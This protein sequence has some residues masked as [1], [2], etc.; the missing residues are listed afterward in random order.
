MKAE[1]RKARQSN[2]LA[3]ELGKVV[4]GIKHG[5]SRST[6]FYV[7]LAALVVAVVGLGVWLWRSSEEA[8]SKRWLEYDEILFPDQ[9][10]SFLKKPEVKGTPQ[11][12][13]ARFREARANLAQGIA[14]LGTKP[15]AAQEKL[16]KATELYEAL[17]TD[18]RRLPILHQEALAGAAR[19]NESLGNYDKAK[20]YYGLLAKEHDKTALGKE[21]KKQLDRLEGSNRQT[22]DEIRKELA[23]PKR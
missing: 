8:A 9:L 6:V 16:E 20:E 22:L 21:A 5:P 7:I 3:E 19:G 13:L 14:D 2:A 1:E 23:P 11:A 10:D 17:V 18:S 15:D 12:Q 4:E